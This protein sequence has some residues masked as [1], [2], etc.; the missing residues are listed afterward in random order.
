MMQRIEGEAI[1]HK[2]SPYA[3]VK[4]GNRERKRKWILLLGNLMKMTQSSSLF[5]LVKN[6]M[7]SILY[8]QSY[9]LILSLNIQ[10]ELVSEKI[11]TTE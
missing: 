6:N 10:K 8:I 7:F 3:A 11:E 5:Q 1:N 2:F 9:K 4:D